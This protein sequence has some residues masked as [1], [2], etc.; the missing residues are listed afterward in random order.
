[1]QDST[2]LQRQWYILISLMS[3]REGLTLKEL[4]AEVK[5]DERTIRRD[6]NTLRK[7]GFGID[8]RV[9]ERGRKHW[10]IVEGGSQVPIHFTWPEAVSLY[11]GRQ[12]LD[13]LAGTHFWQSAQTAFAKIRAML[14][15][16]ALS[17][18]NKASKTF[19]QTIPGR[20]DYSTKA[21]VIDCLMLAIEERRVAFVVYQSERATEPVSLEMYPYGIVYHKGSLYL[22][23]H[24]RDHETKTRTTAAARTPARS[25]SQGSFPSSIEPARIAI[26]QP[27]DSPSNAPEMRIF[28]IDR[29]SDVDVQNL[30]FTPD[31][32]FRLENYFAHTFGI[33]QGESTDETQLQT[34]RI[35]FAKEAAR[36]VE[37]KTWHSSQKLTKGKDGSLVLEVQLANTNEIKSWALGFGP[38]ATILEPQSLRQEIANDLKQILANYQPAEKA[39][40]S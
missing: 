19:L 20:S 22:I 31:A 15:E 1:M 4:S 16:A 5:V 23:A 7:A 37:E 40:K 12:L 38:R 32:N 13:P 34:I 6:L 21:D 2:P 39:R 25:A 9:S 28:K 18:V 8:E 33:Y 11:L 26:K 10:K 3:R 27:V 35:R 14:G 36:Y 30:Q 29:V 24:S 17:Q